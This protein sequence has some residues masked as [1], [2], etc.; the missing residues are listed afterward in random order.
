MF[1]GLVEKVGTLAAVGRSAGGAVLTIRHDAWDTPLAVG[2][3]VAVQGACLTVARTAADGFSADVLDETLARTALGG[4][5]PG[6]RLNLERAMRLQDRLGGHL[7]TG[8]VDGTGT[9]AAVR[10]AGRDR[11]LEIECGAEL[12]EGIV[13]KGSVALD[14]VS[15]T[16]V[17]VTD[18]SFS[19]H[20]IPHSW[21]NT[22]LGALETGD[23]VNIETDLIGKYVVRYLA[24]RGRPS[25]GLSLSDLERAGFVG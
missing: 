15:L 24:G 22:T 9:L 2:E 4:K 11:V 3:S 7:V 17:Q 14:G 13:E 10:P 6:A 23:G 1:T 25:G 16:V 21:E 8:H 19:V 12:L 18:R 20:I 5:A